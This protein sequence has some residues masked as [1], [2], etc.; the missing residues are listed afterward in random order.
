MH[1][2]NLKLEIKDYVAHLAFNRGDKANSLNEAS[3]EEMKEAFEQLSEDP[4]VRVV[5]LSGEGKH[6]C[7][8][9]DLETLMSQQNTGEKCEARKRRHFKEFIVNI[10]DCI[11]AIEK[12]SKPVLAAIQGG[13]IGGGINLAATCDIRYCTEDAYF[14]IREID[15]G[16]VADI[17]VLQR[18]PHIVH[19]GIM[20]ELAYTGRKLYGKEAREI[21]FV[22]QCYSNK[23]EMMKGVGEIAQMI[24]SKSPLVVQ[25]IKE[26]LLF[27]RDHT[28]DDS[29]KYIA[30]YNAGMAISADLMEAF[31]S[32]ITKKKPEFKDL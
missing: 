11:T 29:L 19:P 28:V 26:N 32:Y 1:Y 5:I 20:A 23:D 9:M 2:E 3:W 21:G 24:A 27:T 31:Q 16:I 17:G 4:S 12:C 15:L 6:F 14:T 30:N 7:A 10:Q 13:C 25:G 8:G 22:N 18:M